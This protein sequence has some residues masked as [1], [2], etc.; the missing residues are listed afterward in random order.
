MGEVIDLSGRF[1]QRK[2]ENE[3]A[4]R[5][6]TEDI[7]F[8]VQKRKDDLTTVIARA[9][10]VKRG[11]NFKFNERFI[12]E[13]NTAKLGG[14][15]INHITGQAL[16]NRSIVAVALG[17]AF[18]LPNMTKPD[19]DHE[20]ENIFAEALYVAA[21]ALALESFKGQSP[22]ILRDSND[23]RFDNM[24][25][26][27]VT[28]HQKVSYRAAGYVV[29]TQ[30]DPEPYHAYTHSIEGEQIPPHIAGLYN[31]FNVKQARLTYSRLSN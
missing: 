30:Y 4:N 11:Q 9:L 12:P 10:S 6:N 19:V 18:S 31:P 1:L 17:D 14:A 3:A 16:K 8:I 15:N 24:W 13:I 7:V 23:Q 21:Y 26:P 22:R 28:D 27:H 2:E 29:R 25:E 20:T 5:T